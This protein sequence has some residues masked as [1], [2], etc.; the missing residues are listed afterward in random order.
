MAKKGAI[1]HGCIFYFIM[2]LI[3]ILCLDQMGDVLGVG[4][5][6]KVHIAVH[7]STK[8]EYAIKMSDLELEGNRKISDSEKE[9]L[10][11]L[12]GFSPYLVEL[13]DCFDEV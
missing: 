1:I 4:A 12:K 8:E 13:V 9:N 6:G 3:L 11:R 5:F 7:L 2:L 10:E